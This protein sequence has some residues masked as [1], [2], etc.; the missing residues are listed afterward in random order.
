MHWPAPWFAALLLCVLALAACADEIQTWHPPP[1]LGI[2]ARTP[3]L[4]DAIVAQI[5]GVHSCADI[6]ADDLAA[7]RQLDLSERGIAALR[8][9]DFS[10]LT[11]LREL[12]LNGNAL[13][14][15]PNGLFE[16]LALPRVVHLHDNPGAPFALPVELRLVQR[17]GERLLYLGLPLRPPSRVVTHL[18]GEGVVL[19]HFAA[20]IEAGSY[21]SAETTVRPR[22]GSAGTVRVQRV[23]ADR[24]SRDCGREPCWTGIRLVPDSAPVAVAALPGDGDPPEGLP[25]LVLRVDSQS[26]T[27]DA[28]VE[29]GVIAV[30]S[31][32]RYYQ[33]A[34]RPNDSKLSGT[35]TVTEY[36]TVTHGGRGTS[37]SYDY[38]GQ[39]RLAMGSG[40]S[41]P[42]YQLPLHRVGAGA[43]HDPDSKP[44]SGNPCGAPADLRLVADAVSFAEAER[45]DVVSFDVERRCYYYLTVAQ[46]PNRDAPF[47]FA[48]GDSCV[49]EAVNRRVS[50][51]GCA[52]LVWWGGWG[53]GGI[54]SL[55]EA[56]ADAMLSRPYV[57]GEEDRKRLATIAAC[58]T[59]PDVSLALDEDSFRETPIHFQSVSDAQGLCE[60]TITALAPPDALATGERCLVSAEFALVSSS[61]AVPTRRSGACDRIAH[62]ASWSQASGDRWSNEEVSLAWASYVTYLESLSEAD[63]QR[64]LDDH[65]CIDDV[66][67]QLPPNPRSE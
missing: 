25:T 44:R 26:F 60:L 1:E 16:G 36:T 11:R 8:A 41:T 67:S 54:N 14:S 39:C 56:R 24:E 7:I 37:G 32:W 2:C 49:V 13:R 29:R 62:S 65:F 46:D 19:A 40:S 45:I 55:A 20:V 9:D 31:G 5:D 4:R 18:E 35:C 58:A 22:R 66:C 51:R 43:G 3:A 15:L 47:R 53:F 30:R 28:V 17:E 10:G 12:R 57:T 52:E 33:Y 50:A 63:W 59:L 23:A 48:N 38:E 27:L 64:L 34:E 6:D 61:N 42:A 21:V